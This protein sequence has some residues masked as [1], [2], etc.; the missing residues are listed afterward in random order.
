M[1]KYKEQVTDLETRNRTLTLER[2]NLE[3]DLRSMSTR[4]EVIDTDRARDAEQIQLLEDRLRELELG[5]EFV[6]NI[7]RSDAGGEEEDINEGPLE[8]EVALKENSVTEL[9]VFPLLT[10]PA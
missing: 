4:L 9:F 2:N 10:I 3:L 1:E 5:G 6:D 8:L 7:P